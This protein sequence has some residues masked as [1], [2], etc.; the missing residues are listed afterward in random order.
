MAMNDRQSKILHYIENH[1]SVRTRDLQE[2]C[3]ECTPMTLWRDLEKL[4][5]SGYI[6]RFHGGASLAYT[7]DH[8]E[9]RPFFSRLNENVTEKEDIS[10][11]A[12]DLLT[13]NHALYLDGGSTTYSLARHL[14]DG[15]Y[16][17][18]TSGANIAVELSQRNGFN[19][20][21]LGGQ[22]LGSTLACSGPQAEDMLDS[23]NIDIAVLATSGFSLENGFA[24]GCLSEARLKRHVI[25]KAASCS[26][27][28]M[29]LDK[30][31]KAHPFTFATLSDIDIIITNDEPPPAILQR[32]ES[33]HVKIFSPNDG[34]TSSER[35]SWFEDFLA[36]KR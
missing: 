7:Q 1:G 19:V 3:A 28:L 22:V 26:I 12:V 6:H 9:E 30:I 21:L 36:S 17:I 4:E 15:H 5:E 16:T 27:M 33:E 11:I 35:R 34:Y 10:L 20:N 13:P 25:S 24:C 31:G 29:D 23:I 2:L 18:I 32:M 14:P 8:E